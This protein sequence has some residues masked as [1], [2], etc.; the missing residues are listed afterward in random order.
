MER[1]GDAGD[2]VSPIMASGGPPS[3]GDRLAGSVLPSSLDHHCEEMVGM[4]AMSAER[5]CAGL[6]WTPASSRVAG[7]S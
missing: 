7:S 1:S 6:I 4:E 5:P 2:S 3:L